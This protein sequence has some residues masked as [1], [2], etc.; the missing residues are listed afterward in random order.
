M[1]EKQG[2]RQTCLG[3]PGACSLMEIEE[4]TINK[5]MANTGL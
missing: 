1:L 3:S 5:Q 4:K 2:A